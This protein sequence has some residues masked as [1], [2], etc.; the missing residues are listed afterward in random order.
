MSNHN[1]TPDSRF[2]DSEGRLYL[3]DEA[4]T[5]RRVAIVDGG[6]RFMRPMNKAERRAMK[7]KIQSARI[8][9]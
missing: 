1:Y 4:G 7:R 9:P 2:R 3:K 8:Q 6:I 5:M